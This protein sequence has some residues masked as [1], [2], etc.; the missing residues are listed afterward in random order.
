MKTTY[1]WNPLTDKVETHSDV[2]GVWGTEVL[3]LTT[4]DDLNNPAYK[5]PK[6]T[7]DPGVFCVAALLK[8]GRVISLPRPHR[9]GDFYKPYTVEMLDGATLGF[10]GNSGRFLTREEA[11]HEAVKAGQL[12]EGGTPCLLSEDLW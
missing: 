7:H 8:D 10:L 6:F 3:E 1:K 11:Y 9:H 12:K 4:L 5:G 2:V